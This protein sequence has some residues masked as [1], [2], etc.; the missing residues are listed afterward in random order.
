MNDFLQKI[1]VQYFLGIKRYEI[2]KLLS[3]SN[4]HHFWNYEHEIF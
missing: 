3:T 1:D 4:I 2:S